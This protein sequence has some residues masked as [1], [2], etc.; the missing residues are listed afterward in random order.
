[1]KPSF[2]LLFLLP[3]MTGLFSSCTSTEENISSVENDLIRQKNNNRA[4]ELLE[5]KCYACHSSKVAHENLL[6]PPM[7]AIKTRYTKAT[8]DEQEFVDRLVNFVKHPSRD[9]ALLTHAVKEYG[10]MPK[11]GTQKED[12]EIIARYLYSEEIEQPEWWENRHDKHHS[13]KNVQEPKEIGLNYAL[14]TKKALG[15]QLMKAIEK[16][17]PSYAVEFCT[18]KAIPITDSISKLFNA[19]IN[20]V[21][22]KPRNPDNRAN[23]NEKAIIRYYKSALAENEELNPITKVTSEGTQFFYPIK[24][25]SMCLKCH[26]TPEK[27]ISTTTLTALNELYPS[28]LAKGYGENEIRGIWSILFKTEEK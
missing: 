17:G 19:K 13:K 11:E 18:T 16:G 2:Y 4:I 3:F 22:D 1:M 28:D 26:G 15:K 6:A 5:S 12:L 23:E 14:T 25:N 24:T 8:S 21:S 27:E 20:R 7:I 9:K 10:L